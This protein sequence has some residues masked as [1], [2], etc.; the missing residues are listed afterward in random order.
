MIKSEK[1][2]RAVRTKRMI[3]EALS[4]LIEEKGFTNI[5]I[6]DLTTR[7]DINRGTFYLHYTDKYDLLEKVENEVLLELEALAG[8]LS[9]SIT[10]SINPLNQPIPF[11]VK[12]FEFFQQNAKFMKA[13]LGP[14]GDPF[15]RRKLESFLK[16]NFFE[17]ELAEAVKKEN[18]LIPEDY[19]SAYL[20]AAHLSVVEQWLAKGMKESPEEMALI[21][22][23][24]SLLGPFKVAGIKP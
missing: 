8:T 5:S 6:T 16:I 14:N 18:L 13:I 2:R 7:A 3:R 1:D 15:F 24:M 12:L 20:L 11:A 21:L 22:T 9:S 4:A 17:R 23:K 19:F 10:T